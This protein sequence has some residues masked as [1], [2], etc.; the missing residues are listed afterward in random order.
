MLTPYFDQ[1]TLTYDEQ[2]ADINRRSGPCYFEIAATA[3]NRSKEHE[4][5]A[6]FNKITGIFNSSC[7]A[8]HICSPAEYTGYYPDQ[9]ARMPGNHHPTA[10]QFQSLL[11]NLPGLQQYMAQARIA[12]HPAIDAPAQ[13]RGAR[14]PLQALQPY[15]ISFR[16]DLYYEFY[17][18][19][20]GVS[21]LRLENDF[22]AQK[23]VPGLNPPPYNMAPIQDAYA[24][25]S[26]LYPDVQTKVK[27]NYNR[28]QKVFTEQIDQLNENVQKASHIFTER[29]GPA[30][31][32]TVQ[33]LVA[34]KDYPLAYRRIVRNILTKAAAGPSAL[35]TALKTLKWNENTQTYE[36]IKAIFIE[37]LYKL[38]LAKSAS[39]HLQ[40]NPNLDNFIINRPLLLAN[41][42][43]HTDNQIRAIPGMVVL[44]P[45][46]DVYKWFI[47]VLFTGN[48]SIIN[49][50]LLD[51][52]KTA[53]PARRTLAF[54]DN[55]I[56]NLSTSTII[57]VARAA[58]LQQDTESET[59]RAAANLAYYLNNQPT[60]GQPSHKKIK[61]NQDEQQEPCNNCQK[62]NHITSK[63][64]FLWKNSST[65]FLEN[66][67]AK[68]KLEESVNF[69]D[70]RDKP[71]K[72]QKSINPS[73][74]NSASK[75][76]V[77][78]IKNEVNKLKIP[79][80]AHLAET[81]QSDDNEDDNSESSDEEY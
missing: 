51:A 4:L 17:K 23:I 45:Y 52:A 29:I 9:A 1:D 8:W 56:L 18:R 60:D 66:I 14:L 38:N 3:I 76:V 26:A 30:M 46:D 42:S 48:D 71:R 36:T 57:Q 79:T 74:T 7:M 78:K 68:R 2:I 15:E 11:N 67:V 32:T 80:K 39:L 64:P 16:R 41:G 81:K 6:E 49:G 72:N 62:T 12:F 27:D 47:A 59:F 69:N 28:E 43:F 75:Y 19:M 34:T 25:L 63:C 40:T 50:I 70:T 5:Q 10:G 33:S 54:I 77:P 53:D 37:H 21:K 55:E 61:E 44:T 35:E 65:Q 73:E 13:P 31:L 20:T 22:A 24:Y 58:K